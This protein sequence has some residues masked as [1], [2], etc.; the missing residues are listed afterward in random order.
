MRM[1]RAQAG[2]RFGSNRPIP[3][4]KRRRL[5]EESLSA[6]F[7]VSH[8]PENSSPGSMDVRGALKELAT[9]LIATGN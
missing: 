8:L 6:P 4:F 9:P 2:E 7:I 1:G 5:A 3:A